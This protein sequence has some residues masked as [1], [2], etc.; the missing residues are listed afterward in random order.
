MSYKM[1]IVDAELRESLAASGAVLIE[2]PKACGKTETAL[3]TAASVVRLDI[4]IDALLAANVD[5]ALVL[6]GAAPRLIDEWQVVPAIWNS[7][8]RAV[9]E[10]RQPGQFILTGSAQPADD[11][12]RHSGAGRFSVLRM[13]PMSLFES[14]ASTGAIAFHDLML[15][16]H[17]TSRDTGMSIPDIA[18]LLTIGGWPAQQ[19]APLRAATRAARDYLEQIRQ[20]DIS[21]VG[22]TRRDPAR[23]A[24]LLTSL[25]R[26]TATEAAVTTIAADT[27]GTDGPLDRRTVTDY[28]DALGRLMIVEDQPAWAPH[29]RSKSTLRTSAKRHFVDPSLAIAAMRAG[30]ETLLKDLNTLGL[31][32]ESMVIR[33][34][35]VLSQPLDG[36]VFH[37]RDNKGLEVDAIVQLGDGRWAAFEVKLGS[38]QLDRA[39][40]TLVKF[41]ALADQTRIGAPSALAVIT[42]TGFGYQR[43]DGVSVVPVGSLGP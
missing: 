25:A 40:A 17:Q 43:P 24:R 41:A 10:R 36:Q 34:L 42:A 20:V 21:L 39:A 13:R 3:Q 11:A 38:G 22:N 18:E 7:V 14:G 28:L 27:G 31:L 12:H 19:G 4:D 5:P 23:M 32:F 35:R 33:D 29:M 15:G 9:D 16:I 6:G 37:Y 1:R 8:R 26:N 2:G 30:P